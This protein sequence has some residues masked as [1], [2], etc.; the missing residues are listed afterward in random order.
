M[1]YHA[2]VG[3]VGLGAMG[4]MAVWRLAKRG[5]S[6]LGWD[7]FAPG[8]DQS[9]SGGESRIFRT[10]YKEGPAYVPLLIK[11]REIWRE[12]EGETGVDLLNLIGALSIAHEDSVYMRNVIASCRNYE[13]D[14]EV[15]TAAQV[16]ERYPVH[17]LD[18]GEVAVL[19]RWAGYVQ[20]DRATMTAA[21]RAEALGAEL[22]R[23]T[24]I[25]DIQFGADGATVYTDTREWRVRKLIL[26]M[27][28]W[29]RHLLPGTADNH[30]LVRIVLAWYRTENDAQFRSD[31]FPVLLRLSGGLDFCAWPII[32]GGM[33]KISRNGSHDVFEDAAKLDRNVNPE[34]FV[35]WRRMIKQYL[36]GVIPDPVR[37]GAYMDSWTES[38]NAVVDVHPDCS[39]LVTLYGFSGHGFKLSPVF[40]EIAAKLALEE[41]TDHDLSIFRSPKLGPF[42]AI[43][44]D[45]IAP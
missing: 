26:A 9:A 11:S 16:K 12:L 3:V 1:S 37:I 6:V 19:D 36:P 14:H 40:G 39:N 41:K 13:I 34:W 2:D 22:H 43:P 17:T 23:Y 31:V 29:T 32:D 28:P 42:G 4:S 18:R 7:R 15:L 10:A 25:R 35:R 45:A 30:K 20:P 27:G 8:H 44:L 24:P 38:G 5:V 21:R 33:M